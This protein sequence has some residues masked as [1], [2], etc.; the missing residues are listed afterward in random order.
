MKRGMDRIKHRI[1]PMKLGMDRI[2]HF[3][4]STKLGMDRIEHRVAQYRTASTTPTNRTTSMS[5]GKSWSS[6][7]SGLPPWPR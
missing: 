5:S 3:V 1:G 6:T 2:K 7:L 4:G